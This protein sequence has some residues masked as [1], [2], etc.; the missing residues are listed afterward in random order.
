MD[1]RL[2]F[3]DPRS[4]CSNSRKSKGQTCMRVW[5]CRFKGSSRAGTAEARGAGCAETSGSKRSAAALCS[6]SRRNSAFGM[7]L[8]LDGILKAECH[9]TAGKSSIFIFSHSM[10]PMQFA[11]GAISGSLN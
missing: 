6:A 8:G 1:V 7:E 10:G 11:V 5:C 4:H 2:C 3:A 9:R